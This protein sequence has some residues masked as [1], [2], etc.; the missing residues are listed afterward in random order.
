MKPLS[1]ELWR[2]T[3]TVRVPPGADTAFLME[4]EMA[5]LDRYDNYKRDVAFEFEMEAC[6]YGYDETL[7][8]K[9]WFEA[10]WAAHQRSLLKEQK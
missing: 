7:D 3:L 8:A 1:Y 4:V 10:G 5:L 2:K 6:N 9:Q